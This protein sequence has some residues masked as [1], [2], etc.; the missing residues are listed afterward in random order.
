MADIIDQIQAQ[1]LRVLEDTIAAKQRN[2]EWR[3]QFGGVNMDEPEQINSLIDLAVQ[4]RADFEARKTMDAQKYAEFQAFQHEA[5][6]REKILQDSIEEKQAARRAQMATEKYRQQQSIQAAQ[7]QEH[8]AL[9]QWEM[10]EIQRANLGPDEK[11]DWI[12]SLPGKYPS[13]NREAFGRY[14]DIERDLRPTEI[15][16]SL[17]PP[18]TQIVPGTLKRMANGSM[19]YRLEPIGGQIETFR[20]IEEGRRVHQD[21]KDEDFVQT[22]NGYVYQ[23]KAYLDRELTKNMN[24]LSQ[25]ESKAASARAKLASYQKFLEDNPNATGVIQQNVAQGISLTIGELAEWDSRVKELNERVRKATTAPLAPQTIPDQ[26][27]RATVPETVPAQP[28]VQAPQQDSA[29][30]PQETQ[31][32]NDWRVYK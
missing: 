10:G 30:V 21:A 16:P 25:A 4:K 8:S 20:T 23:K 9:A 6:L 13:M 17:I 11:L 19:T 31:P 1:N 26:V 3:G 15:D 27:P 7:E 24:L 32:P 5:P 22:R 2:L 14:E 28:E 12:R 18:G 29:G